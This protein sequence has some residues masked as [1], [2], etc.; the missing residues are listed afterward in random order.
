M[1]RSCAEA[2]PTSTKDDN[3]QPTLQ[4]RIMGEGGTDLLRRRRKAIYRLGAKPA[5][6]TA[7]FDKIVRRLE[8]RR[9]PRQQVGLRLLDVVGGEDSGFIRIIH[10][11]KFRAKIRAP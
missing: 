2:P 7:P 10:G 9:F 8:Q 1:R 3:G 11:G 5:G 4:K 6:P